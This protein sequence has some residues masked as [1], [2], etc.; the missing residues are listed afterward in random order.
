[1]EGKLSHMHRH[2]PWSADLSSPMDF[3]SCFGKWRW[4]LTGPWD[5]LRHGLIGGLEHESHWECRPKSNLVG[6]LE[7]FLFFHIL[8]MSSSQRGWH[9]QPVVFQRLLWC[10]LFVGSELW[11]R[12]Y[13]LQ[14]VQT[15]WEKDHDCHLKKGWTGWLT[16]IFSPVSLIVCVFHDPFA[17]GHSHTVIWCKGISPK[18][19]NPQNRKEHLPNIDW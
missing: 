8:G 18:F 9:H 19:Q 14:T 15:V 10:L 5:A 12:T 2:M 6:G 13:D 11:A 16:R 3:R 1:M 4:S 7:H 17:E